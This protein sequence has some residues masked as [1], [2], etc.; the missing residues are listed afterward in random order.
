MLFEKILQIVTLVLTVASG[1]VTM[2]Y[3]YKAVAKDTDGK[4]AKVVALMQKG[5]DELHAALRNKVDVVVYS[6]KVKELHDA[7]NA[8]ALKLAETE[9]E[10]KVLN[11]LVAIVI[12]K[13][14]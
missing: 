10:V 13:D 11:E 1:V 4:L 6:A 3:G 12:R 7:N 5:F 2:I 8:L 14:N 9:R